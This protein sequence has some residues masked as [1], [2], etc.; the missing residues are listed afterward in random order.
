M[1]EQQALTAGQIAN[2]VNGRI[3]GDSETFISSVE[4]IERA[5]KTHLTYLNDPNKLSRLDSSNAKLVLVP[6]S[7]EQA[8]S[9]LRDVTFILVDEPEVAFL[10]IAGI[11]HPRR[12]PTGEGIAGTAVVAPSANIGSGTVIGHHVVIGNHVT[13][14][15]NCRIEHGTLIEDGCKLGDQ[16]M[17]HANCV[18]YSDMII[19]S[20]VT[21]HATCVIG[22]DGFGYRT[23]NGHHQRIPH[24]GTVRI[25]DD[26][27][28]GAGTTID[29]AKVG[30]TVIGTGTRIDNQVM[31][32]HNCQIGPHNLIVSQVGFAGSASTGAYVVCAGQAGIAD[33]VHLADGAIIGAK[34]GVHRDM[35]G[36]QSYLGIPA[37]P[38]AETA[39]NMMALRRLPE[40]RNSVKQLERSVKDL[41]KNLTKTETSGNSPVSHP[42]DI[43]PPT[44]ETFDSESEAA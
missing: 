24:Y 18:V 8:V 37:L 1:S 14:G 36:G 29:R 33:H 3:I 31:I 22:A 26:V 19:G 44:S 23:V 13:I 5:T 28:I 12:T 10:Q 34:T 2:L 9:H 21:I 39:R 11:L 17:V 42:N 43:G 27:E 6:H 38:I 15:N 16:V 7:T 41:Q 20:R 35:K 25:C 40:I 4:V 32:G 30:E